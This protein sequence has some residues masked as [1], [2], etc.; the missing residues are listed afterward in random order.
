[1]IQVLGSKPYLS[2]LDDVVKKLSAGHVFHDHE[3]VGGCGDDLR[4]GTLRT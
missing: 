4:Q 3:D 2:M 1:M